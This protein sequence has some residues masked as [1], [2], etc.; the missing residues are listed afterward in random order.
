MTGL[1]QSSLWQVRSKVKPNCVRAV[2]CPPPPTY[3]CV[4]TTK[5]R[6]SRGFCHAQLESEESHQYFNTNASHLLLHRERV[7]LHR[8][9]HIGTRV[10][11]SSPK[12]T[13][14]AS[15]STYGSTIPLEAQILPTCRTVLNGSCEWICCSRI[16][17]SEVA[18]RH[19][20]H[21]CEDGFAELVPHV[22]L[23]LRA[24]LMPARLHVC[25]RYILSE[26]W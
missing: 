10:G 12:K 17:P 9:V 14:A 21:R 18:C 7:L 6:A 5:L 3:L 22:D 13:G 15:S 26:G 16:S 1:L 20:R 23:D 24:L 19:E 11:T 4:T 25:H 2:A 8:V